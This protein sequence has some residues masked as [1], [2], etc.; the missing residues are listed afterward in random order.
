MLPLKWIARGP[1]AR[2]KN[3]LDSAESA[4]GATRIAVLE[5]QLTAY[6]AA[7]AAMQGVKLAASLADAVLQ[8]V[9]WGAYL[10]ATIIGTIIIVIIS[11][12]LV[13]MMFIFHFFS[14]TGA[15]TSRAQSVIKEINKDMKPIKEEL[16]AEKKKLQIRR[17]IKQLRTYLDLG[18]E[19][20]GKQKPAEG[21]KKGNAPGNAGGA[22]SETPPAKTEKPMAKAA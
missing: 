21:D 3:L 14:G 8:V 9:R 18:G 10:M 7:K 16:A 13:L 15:F 4:K 22:T 17:R 12:V 11:P 2:V 20:P 19:D 1:I 6:T 5:T